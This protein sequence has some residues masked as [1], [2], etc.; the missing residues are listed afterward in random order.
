MSGHHIIGATSQRLKPNVSTR[1][2]CRK[3]TCGKRHDTSA[4]K[5]VNAENKNATD[6]PRNFRGM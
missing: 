2:G 4:N 5:D 3:H 6:R 1:L